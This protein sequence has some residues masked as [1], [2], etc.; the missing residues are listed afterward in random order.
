MWSR[1]PSLDLEIMTWAETRSQ[2]LNPLCHAG[3]S[4]P[5]SFFLSLGRC[6]ILYISA[7][8]AHPLT[9]LRRRPELLGGGQ[10]GGCPA[11]WAHR[12][13][14]RLRVEPATG[15]PLS[16]GTCDRGGQR[17]RMSST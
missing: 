2:W 4:A 11:W 6:L 3:A 15:Q 8:L 17:G 12:D 16:E 10:V 9:G 13:I 1:A 7:Y 14:P 5:Y